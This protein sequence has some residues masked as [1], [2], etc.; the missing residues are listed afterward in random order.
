MCHMKGELDHPDSVCTAARPCTLR[1]EDMLQC[2]AG[3]SADTKTAKEN[4][5]THVTTSVQQREA[6]KKY[7]SRVICAARP[8]HDVHAGLM[9]YKGS[10]RS[11]GQ[12]AAVLIR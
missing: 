12:T 5:E 9:P 3:K 11:I 2:A 4:A 7:V 6:P 1:H 10:G 8:V